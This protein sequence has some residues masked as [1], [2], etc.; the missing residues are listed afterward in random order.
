MRRLLLFVLGSVLGSALGSLLVL[1]CSFSDAP[2]PSELTAPPP[3][4]G[5]PLPPAGTRW[6]GIGQVVV[7]V[8]DVWGTRVGPC[9]GGSTDTVWY[10]AAEGIFDCSDWFTGNVLLHFEGGNRLLT[11]SSHDGIDRSALFARIRSSAMILPEGWTTVPQVPY[12]ATARQ[13]REVIE[14]AGLRPQLVDHPIPF[15]EDKAYFGNVRSNPEIGT[16]VRK[17]AIVGLSL[18]SMKQMGGNP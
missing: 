5:L 4:R 2:T 9:S 16:P 17:G 14:R 13:A 7:A 8:P 15:R 3:G 6:Q 18:V 10:S 1:G 12:G 11:L